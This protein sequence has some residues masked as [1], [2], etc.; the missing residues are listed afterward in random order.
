MALTTTRRQIVRHHFAFDSHFC[1]ELHRKII[2]QVDDSYIPILEVGVR[3]TAFVEADARS[4]DKPCVVT[5]GRRRS[6]VRI[7]STEP[8]LV[9]QRETG[10][11]R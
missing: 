4:L 8:D 11:L 10:C 2:G 3:V 7:R 1:R 5:E 6:L 9:R